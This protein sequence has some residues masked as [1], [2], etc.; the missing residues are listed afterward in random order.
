MGQSPDADLELI[1]RWTRTLR[2]KRQDR[3]PGRFGARLSVTFGFVFLALF[4]SSAG[5]DPKPT[6]G[7]ALFATLFLYELP[8]AALARFGGRTVHVWITATCSRTENRGRAVPSLTRLGHALLGSCLS[9]AIGFGV[10]RLAP[11]LKSPELAE[12]GQLQLFWGAAQLLPM[13]PFK[14]GGLLKEHLG[15]W[16]RVK[17]ALASL[18]LAVA[19]LGRTLDRFEVPL[20]FVF[21]SVWLFVC[22]RELVNRIAEA[23]DASLSPP[24]KLAEIARLTRADEP[25]RALRL[26]RDLLD[27]ARSASL[28]SRAST[29][30]AWAAIG[31]GDLDEAQKAMAVIAGDDMDAH[32][33]AAYL[34]T[35]GRRRGAIALLEGPEG[36]SVRNVESL[37]LL[38][39]L[40]YREGEGAKLQRLLGAASDLLSEAELSRI[41]AALEKLLAKPPANGQPPSAPRRYE[42]AF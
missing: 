8:A 30:R 35:T 28:R 27:A 10:C 9:L 7:L 32:L 21:R 4:V 16:A 26:A 19:T 14:L 25:G 18:G 38:A 11:V 34:A 41:R 22:V 31:T 17:H 42:H 33:L 2:V 24:A 15:H 6:L 36:A 1:R 12:L 40:Y 23:R 39:D 13:F 5:S 3:A 29:A 20:I 37:K